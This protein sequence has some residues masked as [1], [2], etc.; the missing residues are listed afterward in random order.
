MEK[1]KSK[2]Y[3]TMENQEINMLANGKKI[4]RMEREFFISDKKTEIRF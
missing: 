1:K 2:E 4:K 3:I